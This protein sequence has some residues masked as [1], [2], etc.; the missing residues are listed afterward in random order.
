MR[1]VIHNGIDF[2]LNG[3]QYALALG[4]INEIGTTISLGLAIICSL[5]IIIPKVIKII[6]KLI[7]WFKKAI[8]DGKIT[9]EEIKEGF[10]VLQEGVE[11]I[12]KG[13]KK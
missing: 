2:L 1:K 13:D 10:N 12:K 9:E 11:D 5:I 6:K 7:N 3:I 4:D 8:A